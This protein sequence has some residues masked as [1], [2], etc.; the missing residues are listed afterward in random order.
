MTKSEASK[1][2]HLALSEGLSNF[3]NQFACTFEKIS[4]LK[5]GDQK[6]GS[7]KSCSLIYIIEGE[8][9]LALSNGKEESVGPG[10]VIQKVPGKS[11]VLNF[12]GSCV[13][14]VVLT[15]PEIFYNLYGRKLFDGSDSP[16]FHIG[17]HADLVVKFRRLQQDIKEWATPKIFK[18]IEKSLKLIAEIQ[19]IRLMVNSDPHM[20]PFWIAVKRDLCRDLKN[21]FSLPDFAEKFSMSYSSFRQGFTKHVGMPPGVF[22]ISQRIEQVKMLLAGSQLSL[23]DIASRFNYPDLPSFSKQFKK[24]TGLTP[25][26]YI[27]TYEDT[28]G[29]VV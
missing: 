28:L 27:R 9:S 4:F 12:K 20:D 22:H 1:L 3:K 26:N 8:G 25:R 5:W 2:S 11:G 21:R 16:V 17:L 24:I 10:D 13:E 6:S 23:K 15:L 14:Q 29:E 7:A 18:I 19:A